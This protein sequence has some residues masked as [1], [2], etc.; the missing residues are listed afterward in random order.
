[1]LLAVT[2]V[3]PKCRHRSENIRSRRADK[4]SAPAYG[5]FTSQIPQHQQHFLVADLNLFLVDL[6]ADGAQVLRR[7]NA[8]YERATRL[9]FP[10]PKEP[11]MQIFFWIIGSLAFSLG[12]R[13]DLQRNTAIYFQLISRRAVT[14]RF[15]LSPNPTALSISAGI[16]RSTRRR[17]RVARAGPQGCVL[18][19]SA[20]LV[21]AAIQ[22]DV[23]LAAQLAGGFL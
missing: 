11:S 22:H 3:P 4:K 5:I 12:L 6:Y 15:G 16:P 20:G 21:S 13:L 10:T 9:V 18:G 14:D 7:K 19:L 1:M 17:K 2:S 23:N 8:L